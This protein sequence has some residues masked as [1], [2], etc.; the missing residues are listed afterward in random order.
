MSRA[1]DLFNVIF[2][3]V[4]LGGGAAVNLYL[5][6]RGEVSEQENRLLEPFPAATQ[7]ELLNG[8]FAEKFDAF[9][10]DR[11]VL[12]DRM[13]DLSI[14]A[15]RLRGF[16]ASFET[17]IVTITDRDRF[18]PDVHPVPQRQV[19]V[20]PVAPVAVIGR[21]REEPEPEPVLIAEAKVV[22]DGGHVNE[23]LLVGDRGMEV[24]RFSQATADYYAS[25]IRRLAD[26][27]PASIPAY[28]I[29]IPSQIAVF[30]GGKHADLG[31]NQKDAIQYIYDAVG[32]SVVPL[33]LYSV[34]AAHEGEDLFFRTDHHWTAEGAHLAYALF[35][36]TVGITAV[37]LSDYEVRVVTGFTGSMF[38]FTRS[39]ELAANPD[40]IKLF[41]PNVEHSY[42]VYWSIEPK[43]KPIL[44]M[45]Y[46]EDQNKYQIFSSSDNP[47]AIVRTSVETDRSII[48]IKDSYGNALI[49]FLLPHY[50]EIHV[51]DPRYFASN[52]GKYMRDHKVTEILIC[53]SYSVLAD[54]YGYARNLLRIVEM[55]RD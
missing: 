45:K 42:N 18:A 8:K 54:A 47:L 55:D 52:L 14:R 24:L 31:A 19:A 35:A 13:V 17:Q 44:D 30:D 39:R 26:E 21:L 40:T 36:E 53:N 16:P 41:V 33:D 1:K 15:T 49:P 22:T 23:I 29:V 34:F 12:R 50:S 11:F 6:D 4:I 48:V 46:A 2:A 37:P 32:S 25:A 7:D 28:L 10:R 20:Q 5:M 27:I 38:L 51:I 9:F 43:Q 3:V